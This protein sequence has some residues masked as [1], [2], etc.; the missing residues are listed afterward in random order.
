MLKKI[1]ALFAAVIAAFALYVAWMPAEGLITRTLSLN[2]TPTAL[3]AHVNDFHKWQAWSPWAKLDPGAKS[4]F[5]GPSSGPGAAFLWDGNDDVG[6][7]KMTIVESVPN[8]RIVMRLEFARPMPGTSTAVFMFKPEG[9]KTQ[10]TWE[11]RGTSG[12]F[13]RA[14]CLLL[15]MDKMVG[16]QFEQG[17]KNLEAAATGAG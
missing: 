14:I 2:A 15:N 16:R 9:S 13:E 6:A 7:G 3:F 5:E 8:E 12:F 1:F 17:L 10:V 11:M 4:S